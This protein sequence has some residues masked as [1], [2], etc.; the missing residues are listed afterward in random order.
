M[1]SNDRN[2]SS[3]SIATTARREGPP[4]RE[5]RTYFRRLTGG[6]RRRHMRMK[7]IFFFNLAELRAEASTGQVIVN[8]IRSRSGSDGIPV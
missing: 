8:S 3:R 2:P 4:R 5:C 1:S 6:S 7:R